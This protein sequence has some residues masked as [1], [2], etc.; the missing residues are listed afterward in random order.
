M[1]WTAVCNKTEP[2]QHEEA[3]QLMQKAALHN[4]HIAEPHVVM[5][6]IALHRGDYE[7]GLG[8]ARTAL[9]IFMEWGCAW[10]KRLTW[11]AWVAWTRVILQSALKKQW[12]TKPMGCPS[13][14]LSCYIE[15]VPPSLRPQT[16]TGLSTLPST[17]ALPPPLAALRYLA[18]RRLQ[19]VE[20]SKA[21]PGPVPRPPRPPQQLPPALAYLL[22]PGGPGRKP[23]RPCNQNTTIDPTPR[24]VEEFLVDLVGADQLEEINRALCTP[25][26][27]TC[28]RVNS[29]RASPM[30]VAE[31]VRRMQQ[32][33]GSPREGRPPFVHPLIPIAVML[34]G[35]GPHA[36]DY[37]QVCKE[38]IISR[39]T[40]EAVLRG[41]DIYVKGILAASSGISKGDL[42][43]VSVALE[44]P[45][46]HQHGRPSGGVSGS[47]ATPKSCGITR[48]SVIDASGSV[49][50]QGGEPLR[51]EDRGKLYI[52]VG[53][54]AV[55][56]SEMFRLA[57]GL[58]VAMDNPVF[59]VP[60]CSGLEGKVM[61]QN[62]PSVVAALALCPKPGSQVLDM[63]AAPAYLAQST[64]LAQLMGN[65]GELTAFDRSHA[66]VLDIC[67][68]ADELG[69]TCISAYKMDATKAVQLSKKGPSAVSGTH[70][71]EVPS[72]KEVQSSKGGPS[73]TGVTLSKEGLVNVKGGAVVG[74]DETVSTSV[75]DD[76]GT[77]SGGGSGGGGEGG[78]KK[79]PVGHDSRNSKGS[80][81]A[82]S[83]RQAGG[84][85]GGEDIQEEGKRPKSEDNGKIAGM[86]KP[87]GVS[88]PLADRL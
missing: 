57:S 10:D 46:R 11:D 68:L 58:G 87:P 41:A 81:R 74:V 60:S 51:V 53:R 65:T 9:R 43:A 29:L 24:Q 50:V 78:G 49:K 59:L 37:S 76:A 64:V 56:R 75:V 30:E 38:V 8:H 35:A 82:D 16:P 62:L 31:H 77:N 12:P 28:L 7:E 17:D 80:G 72:T 14:S 73:A 23:D 1:Y 63:C 15:T 32:E 4:P 84:S 26:K 19:A 2:Q 34:P 40:G 48:G 67:K 6:Q 25:P 27:F 42:V 83:K 39:K 85:T 66:K 3:M 44:R 54:T 61:L 55:C 79:G 20:V 52:G 18:P 33:G 69:L 45:N 22:G 36:V 5:G 71:K 47:G 13:P 70:S 21:P 88:I 86:A